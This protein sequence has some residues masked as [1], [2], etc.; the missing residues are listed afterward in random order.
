MSCNVVQPAAPEPSAIPSALRIAASVLQAAQV[1][2]DQPV[3]LR[4]ENRRIV[5]NPFHPARHDIEAVVAS[6][7]AVRPADRARTSWASDGGGHRP[8]SYNGRAGMIGCCP[9]NADQGLSVRDGASCTPANVVLA[10]QVKMRARMAARKGR[11]RAAKLAEVRAELVAL[12][13]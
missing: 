13:G 8:A 12:R 7:V 9:T 4:E 6:S 3:D 2:L 1:R 5:I 11:V 10:D